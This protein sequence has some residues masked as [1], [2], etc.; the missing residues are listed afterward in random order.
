MATATF[1]PFFLSVFVF[2]MPT[3]LDPLP[4]PFF[5]C[6]IGQKSVTDALLNEEEACFK[7]I[8]S[9]RLTPH[10][11]QKA[12]YQE[13]KIASP[14]IIKKRNL[15]KFVLYCISGGGESPIFIYITKIKREMVMVYYI[16]GRVKLDWMSWVTL[17]SRSQLGFLSSNQKSIFFSV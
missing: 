1:S 5:K 12:H 2:H 8:C 15:P 17:Q 10:R 3:R 4:F 7:I 6:L 11:N 9:F 14:L 13:S 16:L